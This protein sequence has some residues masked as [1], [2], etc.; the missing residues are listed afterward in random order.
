MTSTRLNPEYQPKLS[1]SSTTYSVNTTNVDSSSYCK[2]EQYGNVVTVYLWVKIKTA[3]AAWAWLN[4]VPSLPKPKFDMGFPACLD[5]GT[6][7][8]MFFVVTNGGV[9]FT[10]RNGTASANQVYHAAF[11]YVC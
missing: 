7:Q 10:P 6:T 4:V 9:N 2:L 1:T 5:G 8:A 11:T 3:V